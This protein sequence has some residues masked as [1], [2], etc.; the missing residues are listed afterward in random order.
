M[1]QRRYEYTTVDM[2]TDDLRATAVQERI[3]QREG[4]STAWVERIAGQTFIVFR[5][6]MVEV[7]S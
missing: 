1:S 7:T 5:R 2:Y 3:Y 6:E 4:W